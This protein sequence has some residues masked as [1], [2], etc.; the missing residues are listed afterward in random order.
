MNIVIGIAAIA[1]LGCA[2][3]TL[4][5]HLIEIKRRFDK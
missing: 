1:A 5:D 2:V 4:V 3:F